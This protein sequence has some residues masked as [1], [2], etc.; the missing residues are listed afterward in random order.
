LL[1]CESSHVC[2]GGLVDD[3]KGAKGVVAQAAP[4]EPKQKADDA[5]KEQYENLKAQCTYLRPRP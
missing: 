1:R 3:L 5:P 2:G 4:M